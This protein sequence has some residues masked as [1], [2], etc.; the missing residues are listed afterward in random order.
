MCVLLAG[1]GTVE[2]AGAGAGTVEGVQ[3]RGQVASQ[4]ASPAAATTSVSFAPDADAR[5]DEAHPTANYGLTTTL[6][7]D[8]DPRA[9][10][11]ANLRFTLLGLSGSV[12]SA[13]L[14][15]YSIDGTRDG[16]AVYATASGWSETGISWQNRPARTSAA[17][18]NKGAIGAKAWVEFDVTRLVTGNGSL[19]LVLGD[20]SADGATFASRQAANP[21]QLVVTTASGVPPPSPSPSPSP[22]PPSPPPSPPPP[23]SGLQIGAYYYAWY[24]TARRHWQDGYVR[25]VLSTPQ[26]PSFGEYDSRDPGLIASHLAWAQQYGIDFLICSW[27]G[28]NGYE[29][30]TVRD[31]LLRSPR[32]GATRITLLYE[33]IARLG[34][35]N[36]VINFDAATQQKLIADFDYL[37]GTYFA[38]PSYQRI[39]GRPVVYLYVTRIYRGAYAQAFAALRAHMLQRYGYDVFLVADEVDPV[40]TP[41]PARIRVFDAI[42][43]YTMY[44]DLQRPGWPDDTGFLATVRRTYDAYRS[45]AA[46]EGVRFIPGTLP[47]FNDRGVRLSANHYVLPRELNAAASGSSLFRAFLDLA[48]GYLDPA[49]QTLTITSFNEWHED[50]Q[51]EPTAPAPASTTPATYT[52]GYAHAS[53]GTTLL[54]AVRDFR[55]RRQ[56]P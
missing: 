17:S 41:D 37:A 19:G 20:A 31:L 15:L 46:A 11:E 49:L 47:G 12:V 45:A 5:V 27:W 2:A 8:G 36:G 23:A 34:L 24:G 53:Y 56:A 3:P 29:D 40:G 28:P 52:Q 9:R 51:I 44:S 6:R 16:P 26:A 1:A 4:A 25:R 14:R 48:G 38:N 21:P 55:A 35:T 43:P 30:V 33:S 18:D 39:D 7:A 13:R 54:E 10:V 42:T 22:S 32:I 50:T